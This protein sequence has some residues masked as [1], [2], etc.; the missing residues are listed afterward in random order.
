MLSGM[1]GEKNAGSGKEF[2]LFACIVAAYAGYGVLFIFRTSFVVEDVRYFSLFDDA[3][4]SMRYARNL[5][6]GHGLIWNPGGDAVEGYTNFFWVL[7]M[8]VMHVLPASA[9]KIS[10][11]VQLFSLLLL[12]ANL[13]VIRALAL[14]VSNGSAMI[15][16]G[17]VVLTAWYFPLNNWAL[18]GMEVGLLAVTT[19]TAIL[20]ILKNKDRPLPLSVL[21]LMAV[22]ILTRTEMVL[23]F[24]LMVLYH[25]LFHCSAR[26]SGWKALLVLASVVAMHTAFRYFYYH[27]ILPNT[28]YL[29]L[30]GVPFGI[31]LWRGIYS[32]WSFMMD[33]AWLAFILSCL[34]FVSPQRRIMALLL[35]AFVFQCVYSVYVGGD[36]WEAYGGANRY[37]AIVMPVLCVLAVWSVVRMTSRVPL[38]ADSHTMR[39][40][41]V[42]AAVAVILV[43]LNWRLKDACLLQE[44]PLEVSN[45]AFMVKTAL[46]INR[47]TE[48]AASV[49]VVWAGAIPYFTGRPAIDLLGK[50][51]RHIAHLACN[52]AIPFT[53]GHNKW[54]YQYS[55]ATLQP[56]VVAQLWEKPDDIM[57]FLEAQYVAVPMAGR[58]SMFYKKSSPYIKHDLLISPEQD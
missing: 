42:A 53:P 21:A 51:D 47:T 7:F 1:S 44:L 20:L 6:E 49:A 4:I 40:L 23:L 14:F 38:L 55:I 16:L 19:S 43:S 28:Y 8:A 15:A 45:N 35:L 30:G 48:P 5:I 17:S 22:G 33:G 25:G 58:R 2:L 34:L 39:R 18:Q 54:D 29:K 27:D 12:I 31:R 52:D 26:T 32:L 41:S 10:F 36:A 3:M 13:L 9:A 50:N 46:L 11:F 57:P 24:G 56:D 37:I